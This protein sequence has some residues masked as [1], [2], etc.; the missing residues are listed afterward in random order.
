MATQLMCTKDQRRKDLLKQSPPSLNGID[1]IEVA[2]ADQKTLALHFLFPLPGQPGGIPN[3]AP[4][5]TEGNILIQGGVRVRGIQ[6]LTVSA[7]AEV[8]TITVNAAGDFSIYTLQLV[9]SPEE[10]E[11]PAGFDLQTSS[12]DFSFKV[13]CPSDFD[14]A[15]T[16]DCPPPQRIEPA[17]NYLAK[18]YETFR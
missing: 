2:S 14:C 1:Y 11:I 17:I 16:N 8:L 13:E 5:L 12:M 18:D 4:A 15:P 6:A 9:T 7:A 3:P 10:A